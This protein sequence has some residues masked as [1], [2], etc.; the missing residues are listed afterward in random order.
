MCIAIPAPRIG[1]VTAIR[2]AENRGGSGKK[3]APLAFQR[4]LES[5]V[6]DTLLGEMTEVIS[7]VSVH[8]LV[9]DF[10]QDCVIFATNE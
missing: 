2:L 6:S 8:P 1:N 3:K 10:R 9:A 5:S 7:N 4:G